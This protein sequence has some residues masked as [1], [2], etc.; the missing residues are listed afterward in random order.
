MNFNDMRTIDFPHR[1]TDLAVL[2]RESEN[3][4]V[5]LAVVASLS[6]LFF[7]GAPGLLAM[8]GVIYKSEYEIAQTRQK[9]LQDYHVYTS[10]LFLQDFHRV[11]SVQLLASAL[12]QFT[13]SS[14]APREMEDQTLS[15]TRQLLESKP[16]TC[17]NIQDHIYYDSEIKRL[18]RMIWDAKKRKLEQTITTITQK[19]FE[20]KYMEK[21]LTS[22]NAVIPSLASLSTRQI[23]CLNFNY[24]DPTAPYNSDEENL[25]AS[26]LTLEDFHSLTSSIRFALRSDADLQI[27]QIETYHAALRI[28]NYLG[29]LSF[30]DTW[31]N[32]NLKEIEIGISSLHQRLQG[33]NAK[34]ERHQLK[35][36]L[37]DHINHQ[38]DGVANNTVQLV[39]QV[40]TMIDCI[41]MRKPAIPK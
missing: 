28:Q 34:N 27:S 4:T 18:R 32:Q 11:N 2:Y 23:T 17:S 12:L 22:N 30:A 14:M 9:R 39:Q 5:C 16:P 40:T 33:L 19:I 21:A 26:L 37:T 41:S 8:F 3:K 35:T 15:L 38:I 25:K 20:L 6:G 24:S 29:A 31:F 1:E 13:S 10:R 36:A 7:F